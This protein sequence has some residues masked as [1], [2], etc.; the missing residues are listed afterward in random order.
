[1]SLAPLSSS[2]VP[3][4]RS[5][6]PSQPPKRRRSNYFVCGHCNKELSKKI[7]KRHKSLY[8]DGNTKLWVTEGDGEA[9]SSSDFSSLD[10][11]EVQSQPTPACVQSDE[12]DWSCG[13]DLTQDD[14]EEPQALDI[15]QGKQICCSQELGSH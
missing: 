10:E 6:S 13:L 15:D 9:L 3:S 2:P 12:S 7:F 5:P 11:S 4:P 14:H 1:M 8:Y